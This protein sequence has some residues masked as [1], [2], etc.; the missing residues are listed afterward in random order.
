VLTERGGRGH[1]EHFAAVRVPGEAPPPGELLR[2]RAVAADEDGLT[3]E[4]A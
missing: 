3:V 2:M 4:R 1:T